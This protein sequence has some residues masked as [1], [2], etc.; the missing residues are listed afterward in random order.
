MKEGVA[1]SFGP[2]IQTGSQR[3]SIRCVPTWVKTL[4]W[5]WQKYS[6][7]TMRGAKLNKTSGDLMTC[8]AQFFGLTPQTCVLRVCTA[9]QDHLFE[10]I[11]AVEQV[12]LGKL[13][14]SQTVI[15]ALSR[16]VNAQRS[17]STS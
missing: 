13:Q 6:V 5:L 11:Q 17:F 1:Y 14:A 16:F 2:C 9:P 3:I 10:V 12:V 15:L 4:S 7:F 8:E